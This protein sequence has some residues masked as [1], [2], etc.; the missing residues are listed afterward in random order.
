M[1]TQEKGFEL[2]GLTSHEK[3]VFRVLDTEKAFSV[4][5]IAQLAS[6]PRTT[7]Y[8]VI[9]HLHNRGLVHKVSYG[10]RHK[11]KSW[12][13]AKIKRKTTE[14]LLSLEEGDHQ[15]SNKESEVIAGVEAQELSIRVY[16]G[17]SQ[18]KQAYEQML[19]LSRTER[20][21]VIQGNPSARKVLDVLDR[22]YIIEFQERFRKAHVIIEGINGE[23]LTSL[24][25]GLTQKEKDSH[26]RRMLVSTLVPDQY[27]EFG[28]DILI[29]R[30]TIFLID[31][32]REQVIS[33][34]QSELVKFLR[35]M[36][37]LMKVF[38]KSFNMESFL[39]E[40]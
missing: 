21:I 5:E 3:G 16:R 32:V 35:S 37:S 18:V 6:I 34:T 38:G 20:I 9:H 26:R 17:K 19:L 2:L 27:M 10:K 40:K 12:P 36:A 29:I 14:L 31:I 11:W 39:N 8:S 13:I 25:S 4:T 23:V 28:L 1:K 22:E 33:I 15:D 7:V 24:L 30:D